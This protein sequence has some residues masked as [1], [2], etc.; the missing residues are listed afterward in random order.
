MH[1]LQIAKLKLPLAMRRFLGLAIGHARRDAR[2]RTNIP[3]ASWKDAAWA[4][5]SVMLIVG[6][7]I[8]AVNSA[9]LLGSRWGISH[10]VIGMLLLAALT[11]VPNVIAAVQLA[12][13]GH[14]AAVVSESLN[15]NTLNILVGICLPAL[16]IGFAPPSPSII[17]A[18]LWLLC[19]K[20]VT[21]AIASH[22]HGLH[23]AGG[24]I[25]VLIYMLFASL[26]VLWK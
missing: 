16:L 11:S 20:L 7:S 25:I 22:R 9:V 14:G 8:G 1:P 6:S 23:R 5:L 18:A 2:K 12:R 13:E 15:S 10:T 26:I 4:V 24:A 17:F 19:M 21:L 3:H